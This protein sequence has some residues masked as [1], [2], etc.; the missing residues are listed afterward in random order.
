MDLQN[1]DLEI[2]DSFKEKISVYNFSGIN[3]ES[4]EISVLKLNSKMVPFTTIDPEEKKIDTLRFSRKLLLAWQFHNAENPTVDLIR[5]QSCYIPKKVSS[6]VLKDT[7]EDLEKFANKLPGNLVKSKEK[8][9]L[10][11]EQRAGLNIFKARRDILYF[12]ADKGASVVLLNPEFYKDKVL[13]ILSTDKYEKLPKDVDKSIVRKL[14]LIVKNNIHLTKAEKRAISLFDYKTTNI[15]ALPKIHKSKLVRDC[16]TDITG[17]YMFMTNPSDLSFRLIFGGPKNPCSGLADLV[18]ILLK[19]FL[20]FVKSRLRDVFDLIQKF[21]AFDPKDMPFIE[22]ISVDVKSMYENLTKNL[23]LPALR[24]YL[25]RYKNSLP[26]R[27]SV[28]FVVEAMTFVLDNN[29][30][31][32][33]GEYYRQKTGTAT[34]IKPAPTYADLAMGYF[35]IN[36]FYKLRS[37]LGTKVAQYFWN[38]YWRYLDDGLIFWDKRLGDFTD[39]F[40]ILNEMDPSIK[41]TMDRDDNQLK[42]LDVI[43]YKTYTGF[44]TVVNG[45]DTDSGTYLPFKSAHPRKCKINIPFNMARRVRALTDNDDLALIKMKELTSMLSAGGYPIG[46]INSAVHAAMALSVSDLRNHVKDTPEDDKVIAFVHTYDPVYPGLLWEV[47]SIISRLFTSTQCKPVFGTTRII[48]SRREPFNLLR[49]LQHSNFDEVRPAFIPKRVTRCGSPWCKLCLSIMEGES[50][51]FRNAGFKF[52]IRT[53]MDCTTRN[54]IYALFCGECNASYIGETVSLRS[55]VNTHRNNSKCEDNAVMR[56][57]RHICECNAGFKV[58][59]LLKVSKE[60][61]ITRLVKED[62]LVKLLKPDLNADKRNLLHLID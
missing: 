40:N 38:S 6:T 22:I 46:T 50:V 57:S 49:L 43:I 23:G 51:Y 42:Y 26:S 55:R 47:R 11:M 12:R 48:D 19:P 39:V 2:L 53:N 27:F 9:N 13:E 29:T 60:C 32:F 5:P 56:V 36:L 3:L 37:K 41:F 44:E 1:K 58:C 21:P 7:V 28:N 33:N 14:S 30:G 8:D 4:S 35:E 16:A 52:I 31:Y 25:T 24:Y 18:D 45:K 15:Y 54:L 59:P 17:S 20:V 61:K 10:T 62:N 34:G